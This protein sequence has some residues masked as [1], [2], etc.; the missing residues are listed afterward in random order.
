MTPAAEQ[1][2][3]QVVPEHDP[4]FTL[5]P[6]QDRAIFEKAFAPLQRAGRF[7]GPSRNTTY[8][9]ARTGAIPTVEIC[10]QKFVSTAWLWETWRNGRVSAASAES[11]AAALI[12]A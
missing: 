9:A 12:A 10:G 8:K 6:E 11:T 1:L 5:L 7:L 2:P 3:A 4:L